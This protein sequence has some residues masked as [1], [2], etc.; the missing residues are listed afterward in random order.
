MRRPIVLIL[1][2]SIIISFVYT[3]NYKDKFYDIEG[4]YIEV[5]GIIKDAIYKEYYYEYEVGNF[6]IRDFNKEQK[7]NIGEYIRAK[8]IFKS[9]Y[10][11][12]IDEFDYGMYLKSKGIDGILNCEYIKS[13]KSHNIYSCIKNLKNSLEYVIEDIFR[14]NSSFINALILGD[15]SELDINIK[16]AFSRAGVSHIIALSGLHI[17]IVIYIMTLIIGRINNVVKFFTI[18]AL[19]LLY[20]IIVGFRGS[21]FRACIFS[22][23][24]YLAV[25]IQREYDGIS[26]LCLVGIVLCIINPFNIYDIGVQLSFLAT[27]S[28]IY[29]YNKIDKYIKCPLVSTTLSASILTIPVVYYKF[30]II[31]NV[32]LISNVLIVPTVGIL[33]GLIFIGIIF[34]YIKVNII[35]LMISKIVCF[36]IFYIKSI[37]FYLSDIKYSYIEFETVS[38]KLVVLYYILLMTYMIY[39]ERKTVKEQLNEVRGYN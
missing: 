25:F 36:I 9:S 5:E 33:I 4:K 2:I 34:Y 31:S 26:A 11:M 32:F 18:S 23:I 38:L 6:L 14:E 22:F 35:Y 19:I 17:G 28:I 27:L 21:M 30:N 39:N 16:E 10:N 7:I 8:G 12:V 24:I 20:C 37:V 29:F 3:K 13:S 1:L 15:K